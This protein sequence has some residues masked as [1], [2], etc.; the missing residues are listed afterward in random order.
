M[1][2]F[3]NIFS[4]NLADQLEAHKISQADLAHHLGV[5][6]AAVNTWCKGIKV[7]RMKNID[8][9]CSYLGIN[10]SDLM[11]DHSVEFSK[12][13]QAARIVGQLIS[14]NDETILNI[15]IALAKL[16]PSERQVL[17]KFIN[18]IKGE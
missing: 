2:E 7:P 18:N 17:T 12:S 10:R 14:T 8:Q 11:E 1:N 6:T 3:T 15:L 16:T 4:K 13:A 9:I 5:S